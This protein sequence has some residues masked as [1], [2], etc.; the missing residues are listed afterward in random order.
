MYHRGQFDL[1]IVQADTNAGPQSIGD[2]SLTLLG[3]LHV[4]DPYD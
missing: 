4:G 3:H 2:E 1:R